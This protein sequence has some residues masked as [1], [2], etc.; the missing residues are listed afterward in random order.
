[1]TSR[2]DFA[3]RPDRVS[4]VKGP[5]RLGIIEAGRVWRQPRCPRPPN[6]LAADVPIHRQVRLIVTAPLSCFV[7]IDY[8]PAEAK[9]EK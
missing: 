8:W 4:G 9:P 6:P 7:N 2:N 3:P 1:M 5:P